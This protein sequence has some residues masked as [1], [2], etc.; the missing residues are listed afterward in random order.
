MR[1]YV[2]VD[3]RGEG[4]YAVRVQVTAP[5]GIQVLDVT[6][7]SIGVKVDAIVSED[8]QYGLG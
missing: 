1:A 3:G 5:E 7:S 4:E 6:P 8:F 2:S